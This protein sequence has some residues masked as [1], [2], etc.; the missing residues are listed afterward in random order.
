MAKVQISIDITELDKLQQMLIDGLLEDG[1]H[2]KQY[3]LVRALKIVTETML[4]GDYDRLKK[5]WN[6]KGYDWSEGIAP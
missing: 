6:D 2:H 1:G 4:W 3:A 5:E